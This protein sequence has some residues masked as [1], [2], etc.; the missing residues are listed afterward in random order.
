MNILHF[1]SLH[2]ISFC[3]EEFLWMN[4]PI[5]QVVSQSVGQSVDGL[6]VLI[7]VYIPIY[8]SIYIEAMKRK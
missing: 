1:I 8:L 4:I 3:L 6:L 5:S 2:F 7:A